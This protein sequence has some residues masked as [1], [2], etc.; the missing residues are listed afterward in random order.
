MDVLL[1]VAVLTLPAVISGLQTCSSGTEMSSTQILLDVSSTQINTEG[2]MCSCRLTV[3]QTTQVDMFPVSLAPRCDT[4]MLIHKWRTSSE[5]TNGAVHT[6]PAQSHN[7]N[8]Y[9]EIWILVVATIPGSKGLSGQLQFK[10][11]QPSDQLT[12]ECF[13]P[14]TNSST[15]TTSTGRIPSTS[16][17]T[18]RTETVRSPDATHQAQPTSAPG[19]TQNLRTGSQICND[20]FPGIATGGGVAI[21]V[22]VIY[23]CI[24]SPRYRKS[25]RKSSAADIPMSPAHP[26]YAGFIDRTEEPA[27]IY[28]SLSPAEVITN[29]SINE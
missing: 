12:F 9:E 22:H 29:P 6:P 2:G 18:T 3:S 14:N 23:L 15:T 1:N 24:I 21:V 25:C 13:E 19:S 4:Y 17:P 11:K 5:C 8:T 27:S 7:V 20:N 16:Q 26:T 28:D 10:V